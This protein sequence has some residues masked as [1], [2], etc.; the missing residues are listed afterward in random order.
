MSSKLPSTNDIGMSW[1]LL[2]ERLGSFAL[3]AY[4]VLWGFPRLD[5]RL[6]Q[7][8]RSQQQM[9]AVMREYVTEIRSLKP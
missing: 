7:L 3:V 8:E 6:T 2:L 1:A 5:E 4:V 9:V